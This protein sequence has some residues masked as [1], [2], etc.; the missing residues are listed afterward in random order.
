MKRWMPATLVGI[1]FLLAS[2][3][4]PPAATSAPTRALKVMTLNI[5][6][7]VG[8]DGLLDLDRIAA[9]IAS[10]GADLV[11]L[12]EVDRHFSAR[13]NFVD[14]ASYLA[15]VLHMSV[16]FGANL[17]LDPLVPGQP[18]RQFGNALLSRFPILSWANTLLPRVAGSEQRGLLEAMIDTDNG[19][20]SVFA[21]HLHFA[22]SAERVVQVQAIIDAISPPDAREVLLCDLNASPGSPE[23]VALL[24][25][26]TDAWV[27]AGNG[28]GFT[29]PSSDPQ[30]RIDY[31][32]T[33][34]DLSVSSAAVVASGSSDH[35][36]VVATVTPPT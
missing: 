35:L 18:R 12:Q 26:F 27:E 14:Q 25:R 23:V 6:H 2:C 13:S 4:P 21:T 19:P 31:V 28:D 15:S 9:T 29:F 30:F 34:R 1:G 16:A 22:S 33:S 3:A 8:V 5:H 11:G 36:P 10:S 20:M 32:L 7:G 17:D 24:T